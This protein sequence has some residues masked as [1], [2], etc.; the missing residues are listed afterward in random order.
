VPRL[1]SWIPAHQVSAIT[2]SLPPDSPPPLPALQPAPQR[3]QP[4]RIPV[5][6]LAHGNAQGYEE[7]SSEPRPWMR[8]FARMLDYVVWGI[9]VGILLEIVAP[10]LLDGVNDALL[11][12]VL[13]AAWIPVEALLLSTWGK[14]PGKAML[15]IRLVDRESENGIEYFSALQR[16]TVVWIYGMGC[17]LFIFT[18]VTMILSY[19]DLKR[20]GVSAWDGKM[21]FRTEHGSVHPF[22][23]LLAVS[24][25]VFLIWGMSQI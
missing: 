10:G 3:E 25:L 15:D 7:Y 2:E 21:G 22:G 1:A 16:A 9:V 11:G 13:V 23:I 4:A 17:G 24:V 8:L 5:E 20:E 12:V 19:R 18:L 14:T 6:R